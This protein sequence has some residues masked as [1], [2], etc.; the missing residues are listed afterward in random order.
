MSKVAAALTECTELLLQPKTKNVKNDEVCRSMKMDISW[1]E[2]CIMDSTGSR[3][4]Q[5]A[6]C[7]VV[8]TVDWI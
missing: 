7:F 4:C 3:Q 6:S 5:L 2:N 1:S 8:K